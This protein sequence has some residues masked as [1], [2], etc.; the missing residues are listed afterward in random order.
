MLINVCRKTKN[1]N[2]LSAVY[3]QKQ[4]LGSIM[5]FFTIIESNEWI[6]ILQ[7]EK[8]FTFPFNIASKLGIQGWSFPHLLLSLILIPLNSDVGENKLSFNTNL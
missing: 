4:H 8:I 3:T 1:E 2:G 5:P 7:S 6:A